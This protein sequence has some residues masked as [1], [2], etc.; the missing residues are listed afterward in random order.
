M[1]F[2]C[3]EMATKSKKKNYDDDGHDDD[4]DGGHQNARNSGT[5]PKKA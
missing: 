3:H 1:V 2:K 4:H 5:G